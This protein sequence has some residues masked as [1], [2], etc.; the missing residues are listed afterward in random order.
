MGHGRWD[1]HNKRGKGNPRIRKPARISA[2]SELESSASSVGAS[3]SPGT[4]RIP[5]R[6]AMSGLGLPTSSDDPESVGVAQHVLCPCPLS[7]LGCQRIAYI[8]RCH[9]HRD[10]SSCSLK[11]YVLQLTNRY[12]RTAA[13]DYCILGYVLQLTNR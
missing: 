11:T 12:S 6:P 5:N 1:M 13:N 10:T 9:A 7:P 3:S 4:V 8:D 2:R